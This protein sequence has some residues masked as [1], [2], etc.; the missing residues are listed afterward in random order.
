MVYA[1]GEITALVLSSRGPHEHRV[2]HLRCELAGE[3]VLLARVERAEDRDPAAR[4]FEHV[5][6]PRAARREHDIGRSVAR[7][8]D[9]TASYP[10]A[11]SA[12]IDA[13]A[14]EQRELAVRGTAR[15]S[16]RSAG[17]GLLAGGAQRTAAATYASS[18]SSPSS[19]ATDVG[20]VREAAPDE[21]REEEVARA[22]AGEHPPGAVAAVRGGARPTISTRARRIAEPGNRAAPV[23]LVA[24]RRAL[25]ARDLL[26]PCDE[27]RTRAASRD[28]ARERGESSRASTG[29]T[30]RV[31]GDCLHRGAEV[32]R[33]RRRP[34][35]SP[36]V[37]VLLL[38][39]SD[40]VVGDDAQARAGAQDPRV[41]ARRRGRRDIAARP[42]RA[43]RARGRRRRLRRR[44]GLRGRRH[45]QRG[46]R[47]GSLHT[48]TA[49]APLP[50]RVD[51]R[52]RAHARATRTARPTRPGRWSPRS[53]PG[54]SRGSASALANGRPF[55]FCA[56]IG[57][58]AAVIRR[59]ERHGRWLK[60][61]RVASAPRRR[62]VQTFFSDDGPPHPR[63]TSRSTTATH[64]VATSGS[65]SSRRRRP[66]PI[67]AG[68]RST[69]H[70]RR[71][72]TP[73]CRSPRSRRS[74]AIDADRRRGV[75][76]A[77]RPVPRAAAATSIIA[78]RPRRGCTSTPTTPF[79]Y[80]VDGDTVGD[81]ER[82]R[83]HAT[84]PTRSTIV[85]PS[86]P[87][88]RSPEARTARRRTGDRGPTVAAASSASVDHVGDVGDDAV[89]AGGRERAASSG[90]S[91]VHTSRARPRRARPRCRRRPRRAPTR[92]S[93]LTHSWPC[94]GRGP[95]R[96]C[97]VL[98]VREPRRSRCAA[99][100]ARTRSTA[101]RSND[102]IDRV[103]RAAA[104][105]A[106]TVGARRRAR[107]GR[108]RAPTEAL[109]LDVHEQPAARVERLGERRDR[110][111]APRG[112]RRTALRR[113]GR[114]RRPRDRGAR[115]AR[116]R[117]CGARRARRR[118]RPA[119][120]A[121]ANA[122][123]R[124]LGRGRRRAAV[125]EH[126]RAAAPSRRSLRTRAEPEH[127][128][129]RTRTPWSD[130]L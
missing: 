5:R 129:F 130:P 54:R 13:H 97:D 108:R 35:P 26:A 101:A 82:A 8:I 62:R 91:T 33:R 10:N 51:Q 77:H 31:R 24:E 3:R 75:G 90:S 17:V 99:S 34:I 20:L 103:G 76:D 116:R 14:V 37:R 79:P 1:A 49:L 93:G 80:Q 126:E 125:A 48:R 88:R 121:S 105:I 113:S 40:R 11:P 59:V 19:R 27:A 92:T 115:R 73:A 52:V 46:G 58:D 32:D 112:A 109:D 16:S 30:A 106:S 68:S 83:D 42:R 21:R 57:F 110:R 44:R 6:E 67:S 15:T 39:N 65:R 55:L 128:P 84:S 4:H 74:D 85:L 127:V 45:A 18:S 98:A 117:R 94:V 111:A 96:R 28:L 114:S 86:E 119:H 124:V 7:S 63:S 9:H 120:G 81:T 95:R 70:P 60:R 104:T 61:V 89:D 12:T 78:R 53:M 25:L 56:G 122:L 100:S 2:E 38:V 47:P 22:V 50:G 43:A 36:P 71:A 87:A 102:E 72:S 23:V 123:E 66:T 118:R 29:S 41:R 64:L 69:S 107:R